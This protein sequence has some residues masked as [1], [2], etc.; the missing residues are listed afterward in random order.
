MNDE[1]IKTLVTWAMRRHYDHGDQR[2]IAIV[3]ALKE[4]LHRRN[5]TA[6]DEI[7]AALSIPEG[8]L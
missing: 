6:P 3:I 8:T 4:L 7:E 2:Y 5:G 1:Q